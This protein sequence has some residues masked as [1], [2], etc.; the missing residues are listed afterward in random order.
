MAS[1][2]ERAIN[3][4]PWQVSASL[5]GRLTQLLVP[6]KPQPEITIRT[7]ADDTKE[8]IWK[9]SKRTM[10]VGVTTDVQDLIGYCAEQ[11]SPY[12]VG[13]RLKVKEAWAAHK[14]GSAMPCKASA[15]DCVPLVMTGGYDLLYKATSHIDP[16]YPVYW[17]S[18]R[19]MPR[20]FSRLT[21]EVTA[22]RI[23]MLQDVNE[24][25]ATSMSIRD[26]VR[27]FTEMQMKLWCKYT[28]MI[29]PQASVTNNRAAVGVVWN[30]KH[31]GTDLAW[32][33]SPWVWAVDYT[34]VEKGEGR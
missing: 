14:R 17:R 2:P 7:Y 33:H 13:T 10:N 18:A 34:V 31:K 20:N 9:D 16:D 11:F 22:V 32:E 29:D 4:Q 15:F 8:L 24:L 21:L 23:I 19:T 12:K 1:K 3:F 25:D 26:A 30:S 5:A 6:V 27:Q 28:K